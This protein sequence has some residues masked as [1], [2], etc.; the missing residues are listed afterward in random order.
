MSSVLH[1]V[2]H[3]S[4]SLSVKFIINAC[5]TNTAYII[6]III[7]IHSSTCAPESFCVL[8]LYLSHTQIHPLHALR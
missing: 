3:L 6:I 8:F 7:L 2:T 5:A 4:T 1:H